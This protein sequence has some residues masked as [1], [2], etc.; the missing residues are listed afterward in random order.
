MN[1]SARIRLEMITATSITAGAAGALP[2]WPGS[3]VLEDAV[4]LARQHWLEFF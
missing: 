4:V 3:A 1:H 2:E